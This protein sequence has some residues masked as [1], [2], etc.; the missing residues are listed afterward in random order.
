M[1]ILI[2]GLAKTGTTALTYAIK[3]SLP[4]YEVIFE[5]KDLSLVDTDKK[6][7]IVKYLLSGK[8]WPT[9]KKYLDRFDKKIL[10]VRHPFDQFI[11]A[12]LYSCYDWE[13]FWQDDNLKKIV[14]I[15]KNKARHPAKTSLSEIISVFNKIKGIATFENWFHQCNIL[16]EVKK[17]FETDKITEPYVALQEK[18]PLYVFFHFAKTGGT[19]VKEKIKSDL[20]KEEYCL[21][22][23]PKKQA[24]VPGVDIDKELIYQKDYVEILSG[25]KQETRDKIKVIC[26]HEVPFNL[27]KIFPE[28]HV[29]YITV[30]RK[31]LD[32]SISR[33]NQ[34][35]Y[36]DL[37]EATTAEERES[38]K[39]K[40]QSDENFIEFLQKRQNRQLSVLN[41]KLE[42]FYFVG[43]TENSKNDFPKIFNLLGLKNNE[44]QEQ[45]L[46]IRNLKKFQARPFILEDHPG[47]EKEF[48]KALLT[49]ETIYQKAK[50]IRE[51]SEKTPIAEKTPGGQIVKYEDFVDGDY[52]AIERY[53]NIKMEKKFDINPAFNRV[54]RTKKYGDWKNWFIAKDV[55]DYRNNIVDEY[56]KEF[57]YD[58]AGLEKHRKKIL[59][60]N[61]YEYIIRI[62]NEKRRAR[63]IPEYKEDG[64]L[65]QL[66]K[67][68]KNFIKK[69]A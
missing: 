33:Y 38:I 44:W 47:V 68:I 19:T 32:R 45:N 39:T 24:W 26:G 63:L 23:A 62:V 22:Y 20:A 2:L 12:I 46:T 40:Y 16:L 21:L 58:C 57:G 11:S 14:E 65:Q 56:N 1:K 13:V 61:S 15:L 34:F 42:S 66:I 36:M 25:L 67:K 64:I 5:P 8:K 30:L 69:P 48:K 49:E 60:K 53:L 10:I 31:P 7:I 27:S 29:R 51:I 37:A 52:S 54:V 59:A 9:D 4:A 6:N 18:K 3:N 35:Y 17:I 41:E 43:F 55:E 50:E 28:R